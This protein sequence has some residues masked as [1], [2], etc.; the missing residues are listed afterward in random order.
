M[1]VG[2]AVVAVVGC[3]LIAIAIW[4]SEAVSPRRQEDGRGVVVLLKVFA[5]WLLFPLALVASIIAIPILWPKR[6]RI[7]AEEREWMHGQLSPLDAWLASKPQKDGRGFDATCQARINTRSAA[8]PGVTSSSRAL[9]PRGRSIRERGAGSRG[10][11]GVSSCVQ[12]LCCFL[13]CWCGC[14]ASRARLDDECSC[15]SCR[16]PAL[17]G[18]ALGHVAL[19]AERRIFLAEVVPPGVRRSWSSGPSASGL[20]AE[21]AAA[22]PVGSRRGGP[23]RAVARVAAARRPRAEPP[24]ARRCNLDQTWRTLVLPT[25]RID[26]LR[27]MPQPASLN[28]TPEARAHPDLA[29]GVRQSGHHVPMQTGVERNGDAGVLWDSPAFAK[30]FKWAVVAFVLNVAITIVVWSSPSLNA[31]QGASPSAFAAVLGVS[32][33]VYGRIW[34]SARQGPAMWAKW[35]LL[36]W[37]VIAMIGTIADG[38]PARLVPVGFQIAAVVVLLKG[39]PRRTVTID[40]PNP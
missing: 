15:C 4:L 27:A 6:R 29:L 20:H 30:A 23:G 22:G 25:A 33:V 18:P 13:G 26:V 38:Q 8:Q 16:Y 40:A 35:V 7:R 12:A 9:R 2:L 3:A 31:S 39:W 19:G 36:V 5:A 17:C 21:P 37:T 34:Y 11:G 1:V 28:L 10:P 14:F 32:A 24:T